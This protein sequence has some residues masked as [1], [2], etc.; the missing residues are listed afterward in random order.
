MPEE[1]IRRFPQLAGFD[2]ADD[3]RRIEALQ[4]VLDQLTGDL[5]DAR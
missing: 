4:S 2:E 1:L 3:A 5:D